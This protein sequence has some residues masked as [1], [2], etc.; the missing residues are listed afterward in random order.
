MTTLN[1]E[2]RN[3]TIEHLGSVATEVDLKAY[4][5]ALRSV[6]PVAADV[7]LDDDAARIITTAV[8]EARYEDAKRF[9][10]SQACRL[11]AAEV[12]P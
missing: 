6:W 11:D 9:A 5:N 4:R 1:D 12:R 10:R 7:E 8:L 3:T 2:I